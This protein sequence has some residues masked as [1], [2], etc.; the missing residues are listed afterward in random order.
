M[1]YSLPHLSI[2]QYKIEPSHSPLNEISDLVNFAPHT[3][4]STSNTGN[5]EPFFYQSVCLSVTAPVYRLDLISRKASSPTSQRIWYGV[6]L[7]LIHRG[8][9]CLVLWTNNSFQQIK[10]MAFSLSIPLDLPLWRIIKHRVSICT[11]R[12]IRVTTPLRPS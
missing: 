8:T 7:N 11:L 3:M 1:A 12:V 10:I 4:A 2:P 5:S 6:A 9:Q